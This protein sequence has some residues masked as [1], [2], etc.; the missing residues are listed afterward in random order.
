MDMMEKVDEE[1][2]NIAHLLSG[3]KRNKDEERVICK[4]MS[5]SLIISEC[6]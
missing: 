4:I 3:Y 1:F 5:I 6:I 2:A